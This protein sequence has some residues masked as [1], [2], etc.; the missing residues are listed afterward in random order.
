MNYQLKPYQTDARDF[1]LKH[2]ACGIFLPPGLGK[3]LITLDAINILLEHDPSVQKVLIIA[4][5]RV[6][7]MVWRQ[8]AEKWGIK[9]SIGILHG[10]DKEEVYG[11]NHDIY[12]INPEG[13]YWLFSTHKGIF[14]Q[15]K[16]ML[17][18]DES[19]MFK[20]HG[21][22]RFKLMKYNLKWFTRKVL[23][24]GTP[25][26]NSLLQLWTQVYIL[27][28]G[29]RLGSGITKYREKY[30]MLKNPNNFFEYVLLPGKDK[31]IYAAVD[32]IIMHKDKSELDLPPLVHNT[33]QVTLPLS[34][35]KRY[36]TMRNHSIIELQNDDGI[37]AANAAAKTMALKQ[38]ANG[39][40]YTEMGEV[41]QF[42]NEKITAL[43]EL[44][45]S[46]AGNPLLVIYEF[47]HDLARLKGALDNPP[48]IGGGLPPKLLAETIS[49]WNSGNV[50]V[51]LL[52]TQAGGMGLNLQSGG[53]TDICW[54]SIT[55]DAELYEQAIARVW[56]QGV[57]GSVTVH[58]IVAS[59]TIDEHILKVLQAKQ[60]VQQALL[61]YLTK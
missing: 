18:I 47:N 36:D 33:I 26:P 9:R 4:P 25:T 20:N 61:D 12:I 37:I 35:R 16:F 7:Y 30:F 39:T 27:D 42:H 45:D 21:T 34:V 1:I 32:D 58:H 23:L 2:Y 51:L 15:Y 53:C 46:L 40:S 22:V 50:P 59:Q 14:T 52:Q 55:F 48:H 57:S 13:L 29:A 11:Q 31:E 28:K 10:N 41:E 19:S 54:F 24:T 38:I 56:R 17:V 43:L 60:N 44:V 6:M 49:D 3:S 8:E 5:I